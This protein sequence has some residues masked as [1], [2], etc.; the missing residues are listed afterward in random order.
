MSNIVKNDGQ[1]D[2]DKLIRT[3]VFAIFWCAIIGILVFFAYS[4]IVAGHSAELERKSIMLTDWERI[5]Q[6]KSREKIKVP[7]SEDKL[8]KG[9]ALVVEL[10]L[11]DDVKD[12]MFFV[13]KSMRRLLVYVDDEL[14][15]EF[16]P[17]DEWIYGGPTRS[18][19]IFT[20][21][22]TSDAGKTL[23]MVRDGKDTKNGTISSCYIVDTWGYISIAEHSNLVL[24]IFEFLL[25]L[26]SAITLSFGL[27]LR[28]FLKLP[29]SVIYVAASV[30]LATIWL[31]TDNALFPF[32]LGV[33]HIG[34]TISYLVLLQL[35][36]PFILFAEQLLRG[37]FKKLFRWLLIFATCFL[38]VFVSMYA[39]GGINLYDYIVP[40]NICFMI[41]ILTTAILLIIGRYKYGITEKYISNGIMALLICGVL[42]VINILFLSSITDGLFMYIGLLLLIAFAFCQQVADLADAVNQKEKAIQ[43]RDSRTKFLARVSHDFKTP[44]SSIT[45][46][47]SMLEDEKYGKGVNTQ[48]HTIKRSANYIQKLVDDLL[49]LSK[50]EA[51]QEVETKKEDIEVKELLGDL[52]D[53]LQTCCKDNGLKPIFKKAC[54][55]PKVIV[56]DGLRIKQVI[57]NLISNAAKYTKTGYVELNIEGVIR[58]K[59]KTNLFFY[60]KDS[61]IGIKKEEQ[62]N[63]YNMFH[64][65]DD[66]Q[67][68]DVE[69]TGIGLSIVKLLVDK[70]DGKIELESE[71]GKGSTFKVR[72]PVEVKDADPIGE[73]EFD[74]SYEK[75]ELNPDWKIL[76]VEDNSLNQYAM[77]QILC[78]VF[79]HVDFAQNGEEGVAR[80]HKMKYDIIFMDQMMPVMDGFEATKHIRNDVNCSNKKT[81]II[82]F[83]GAL[84]DIDEIGT[85]IKQGFTD[86]LPKPINANQV[87]RSIQKVMSKN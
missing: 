31:I 14:R 37:H 15:M 64:R 70:L 62:E 18:I 41:M 33:R 61:G 39:F 22:S 43:E 19:A 78:N 68:R 3:V 48:A 66:K 44:L 73:V 6:D 84:S 86:V 63:I 56:A 59:G 10:V 75:V 60:V 28:I 13:T 45:S 11:P 47:S 21:L 46:L 2:N 34:A 30:F 23:R 72:I 76:V 26:I 85:Y 17:E 4:L 36:V 16:E 7:F 9:E 74:S 42:D 65:I 27:Y 49:N 69:G 38:L 79:R 24:L 80:A 12:N 50:L 51:S 55:M 52:Y 5:Y 53:T 1:R 67:N 40:I 32:V 81:P 83:T 8:P 20:P 77:E 87:I 58:Q 82:A 35:P 25:L 71:Y 57:Y 29:L 54:G